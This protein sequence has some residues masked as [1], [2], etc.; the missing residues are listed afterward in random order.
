MPN[1][2]RWFRDIN[3]KASHQLTPRRLWDARGTVVYDRVAREL[4]AEPGVNRV[5]DVGGGRTWHYGETYKSNPG[6]H[7]IGIDISP[8]E[9]ALNPMLDE[10]IT[11]DI[12]ETLGVPDESIDLI[13]CRATVEHL[14]DT[15]AFLRNVRKALK[16]GGKAIFVF[17][18]KWSPPIILNRVIPHKL[19][20]KLLH[21]LVPGTNGYGG[22]R[23]YYDKCSHSA[24]KRE[25]QHLGFEI[26]RDYCSYYSS[27]YFQFF[28]PLHFL[29]IVGDLI[30]QALSIRNLSAMNLFV[31]RRPG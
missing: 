20:S 31:V 27:S 24:F 7:L 12:C 28:L 10:A 21:A 23:A 30:R 17:A 25:L 29:S 5:A 22:F 11:A 1:L 16:P 13:L 19:A 2:F 15:R 9:L 14:Q 4:L 3:V 26:E 8:S 6:W 18:G